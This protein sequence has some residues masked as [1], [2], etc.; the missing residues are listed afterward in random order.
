VRKTAV[1]LSSITASAKRKVE[2]SKKLVTA[3]RRE[4]R[5]KES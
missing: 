4:E 1:I 3:A 5:E 2:T